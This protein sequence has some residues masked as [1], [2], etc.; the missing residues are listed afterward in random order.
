MQGILGYE[1]HLPATFGV[2][3]VPDQEIKDASMSASQRIVCHCEICEEDILIETIRVEPLKG[4]TAKQRK[5]FLKQKKPPILEALIE[6][7]F[8]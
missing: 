7:S 1:N 8:S 5:N 3:K 4:P 6:V 2:I